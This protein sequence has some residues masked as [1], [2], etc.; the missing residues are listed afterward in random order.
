MLVEYGGAVQL[1]VLCVQTADQRSTFLD[2][3]E[4]TLGH[5]RVFVEV[6]QV[7][8][9]SSHH[10]EHGQRQILTVTGS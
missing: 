7:R 8:G 2:V 5:E 10:S 3:V 1:D 6:H 4:Q 9:L